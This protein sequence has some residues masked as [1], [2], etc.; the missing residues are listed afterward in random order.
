ME[1]K[2]IVLVGFMG[3]GKS[4]TSQALAQRLGMMR[5]STDECI[6]ERESRSINEIFE[7]KGEPY[8][9]Q[10]ESQ[11][12]RALSERVNVVIDCGGGV[13]LRKENIEALKKSG[14]VVYLEASPEVIYDRIK[15]DSHRP[16]LNNDDPLKAISD[17]L[18]QRMVYYGQ[19]D[20]KVMTDG[21]T[22]DQVADEIITFVTHC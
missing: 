18:S 2:N 21:K 14:V 17:L 6:V 11:V 20:Y 12:V 9:R 22:V 16:L 5:V 8:F 7:M 1:N 13:V 3:A 15:Q 10:V 4:V 19:A